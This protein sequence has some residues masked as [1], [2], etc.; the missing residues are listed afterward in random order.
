MN[1]HKIF[2]RLWTTSPQLNYLALRKKIRAF[3]KFSIQ[4]EARSDVF[5]LSTG[6]N[7]TLTLAKVLALTHDY[8]VFHEPSPILYGLSKL[9]YIKGPQEH[10]LDI[11]GEAFLSSRQYLL[12]LSAALGK[13]YIETSPQ[14][15]F[16]AKAIHKVLPD[17]KFIHAVRDPRAVVRSMMR[18]KWY[19]GNPYDKFRISPKLGR[20]YH[21]KWHEMQ[22]FEKNVWLWAETNRWI[23]DFTSTLTEEKKLL[24][25]AEEVFLAKEDMLKRLF[26]FIESPL[27]PKKKI[28]R[29]TRKK[30]NAQV[31]G[32][33]PE[34]AWWTPEM[35]NQ[36][37]EIAGTT[38]T[39]LGYAL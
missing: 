6:R 10:F 32:H 18:R 17:A 15:T 38:A 37:N 12:N 36:M 39:K 26:E 22:I 29:I 30:L 2:K 33:F 4:R 19:D 20:P 14:T 35:H 34:T 5:V 7:G 11:F 27:P 21:D 9:C 31:K 3:S 25:K 23:M 8:L 16:L 13:G 24:I 28:I 1:L